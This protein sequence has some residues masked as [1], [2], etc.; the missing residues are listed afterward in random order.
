LRPHPVKPIS[1]GQRGGGKGK[2]KKSMVSVHDFRTSS[3]FSNSV[4]F[5]RVRDGGRKEK[6]KT[7]SPRH[8]SGNSSNS[9]TER[10]RPGE[11]PTR[12]RGGKKKKK[13]KKK[14]RGGRKTPAASCFLAWLVNLPSVN[15]TDV[16]HEQNTGVRLCNLPRKKKKAVFCS[17]IQ[18]PVKRRKKGK[19]KKGGEKRTITKKGRSRW[20]PRFAAL[21]ARRKKR[22][23]ETAS[24][25][26]FETILK[27]PG[28]AFRCW[29]RYGTVGHGHME[30][31]KKK[32]KKRKEA[33]S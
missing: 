33:E 12:I 9:Q 7:L 22:G 8:P 2:R 10:A 20:L 25:C 17:F 24:S 5:S 14:G 31:R 21:S 16:L 32:K 26:D 1:G 6:K 30:K 18:R 23:G 29:H 19:R 27:L 3:C 4:H 13:K 28:K 11:W 15:V